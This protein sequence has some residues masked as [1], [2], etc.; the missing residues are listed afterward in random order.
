MPEHRPL[1]ERIICFDD[2]DD[3]EKKQF[4]RLIRKMLQ[5]ERQDEWLQRH[6]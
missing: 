1:E 4:V 5:W 2:D 6:L 3:E